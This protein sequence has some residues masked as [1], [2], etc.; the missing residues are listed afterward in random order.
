MRHGVRAAL[1]VAAVWVATGCTTQPSRRP[2]HRPRH[3]HLSATA[4][5]AGD[6]LGRSDRFV[7]YLP[8]ANESL[9]QIAARFLGAEDQA[10]QIAEFNG[11]TRPEAG[12]PVVVPL[13]PVNPDRRAGRPVPDGADPLLSP[14]QRDRSG[15]R[16]PAQ[17]DWQD[18][19]VG[20]PTLRR[21]WTG[22]R[23]TT[24]R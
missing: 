17:P 11:I 1:L 8:R 14:L 18:G 13:K 10:W 4:P 16:K 23:A 19:G 20:E 5:A 2:P 24:T 6:V 3:R 22:W 7:I 21:S 12:Q 15:Q 9:R